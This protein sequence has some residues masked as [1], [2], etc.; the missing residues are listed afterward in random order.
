M[1][2]NFRLLREAVMTSKFK[3]KGGVE[4]FLQ[5]AGMTKYLEMFH[6]KGYDLESDIPFLTAHD[7]EEH[8]MISNVKDRLAILAQG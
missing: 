7:L 8:L 2:I 3:M 6:I 4:A 1:Q 5:K